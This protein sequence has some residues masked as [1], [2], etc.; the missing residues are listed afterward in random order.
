MIKTDRSDEVCCFMNTV[1]QRRG[2]SHPSTTVVCNAA[3]EVLVSF[4]VPFLW[5]FMFVEILLVTK[6]L[7]TGKREQLLYDSVNASRAYELV[8]STSMLQVG[9]DA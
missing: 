9:D 1:G 2:V 4:H 6:S 7:I 8:G 5:E 3:Y